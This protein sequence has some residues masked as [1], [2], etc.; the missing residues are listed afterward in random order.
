MS[1]STGRSLLPIYLCGIVKIR[2]SLLHYLL[3][4]A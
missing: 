3:E 2:E 1:G 4:T